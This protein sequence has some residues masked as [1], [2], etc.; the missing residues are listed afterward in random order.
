MRLT[1]NNFRFWWHHQLLTSDLPDRAKLVALSIWAGIDTET[2]IS[3]TGGVES[4][5]EDHRMGRRTVSNWLDVLRTK[6]W[7]VMK[8]RG[9]RR[10]GK[11]SEYV[12]AVPNYL[13][14][15]VPE[16]W[17]MNGQDHVPLSSASC[18]TSDII[19]CSAGLHA[20]RSLNHSSKTTESHMRGESVGLG[21]QFAVEAK[22]KPT[23]LN[24]K[25]KA[26]STTLPVDFKVTEEMRDW[27]R[28]EALEAQVDLETEKFRDYHQAKGSKFVD[29]E[30]AWRNWMRNTLNFTKPAKAPAGGQPWF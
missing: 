4:L 8:S 22:D 26:V 29:W 6:G 28:N 7:I 20:Y 19:M 25:T 13:K 21:N 11:C 9:N 27:A 12:L 17:H 30:A 3:S 1:D 24:K 16:K 5:M 10:L 15:Q 23:A 14:D 18:A 2:G